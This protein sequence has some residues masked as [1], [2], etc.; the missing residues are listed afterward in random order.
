M[1]HLRRVIG[2][3]QHVAAPAAA[4]VHCA[5]VRHQ[6]GGGGSWIV[7][8]CC[9]PRGKGGR[10]FCD[11]GGRGG[12]PPVDITVVTQDLLTDQPPGVAGNNAKVAGSEALFDELDRPADPATQRKKGSASGPGLI[13]CAPASCAASSLTPTSY[14]VFCVLCPPREKEP[15]KCGADRTG[16]HGPDRKVDRRGHRSGFCPGSFG[17]VVRTQQRTSRCGSRA[18]T[19]GT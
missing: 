4:A 3:P 18:D 15:A 12:V 16:R 6:R 7:P 14:L 13:V 17:V 5:T 19:G 9:R 10:G 11:S 2:V 8:L 1:I